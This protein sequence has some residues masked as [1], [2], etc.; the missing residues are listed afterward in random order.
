MR[1]RFNPK[2]SISPEFGFIRRRFDKEMAAAL[3]DSPVLVCLDSNRS[4]FD[5]SFCERAEGGPPLRFSCVIARSAAA[6]CQHLEAAADGQLGDGQRRSSC[7]EQVDSAAFCDMSEA[8]GAFEMRK[9]S[10]SCAH[11]VRAVR[12][13]C[14]PGFSEAL[15]MSVLPYDFSESGAAVGLVAG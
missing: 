3:I 8:R 2:A 11:T 12:G 6:I 1:A 7:P 9:D 5:R 10:N 4:A 15:V 14:E 13:P